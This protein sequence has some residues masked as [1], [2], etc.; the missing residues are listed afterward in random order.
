MR[1]Q[2]IEIF[3]DW[4]EF[5]DK[6]LKAHQSRKSVWDKY[7]A[8]SLQTWLECHYPKAP[9]EVKQAVADCFNNKPD[10]Y[11]SWNVGKNNEINVIIHPSNKHQK[12]L[13][14]E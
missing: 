12:S 3:E 11:A 9:P 1:R 10:A 6:D 8:P 13:N 4:I 14:N 7:R 5:W 2:V